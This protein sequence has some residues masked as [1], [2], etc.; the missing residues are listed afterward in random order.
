MK[1]FSDS[2]F[3]PFVKLA[4]SMNFISIQFLISASII[5]ITIIIMLI[6]GG[7]F[8]NKFSVIAKENTEINNRQV[9]HQVNINLD[10]YLRNMIDISDS[11]KDVIY[12]YQDSTYERLNEQLKVTMGMRRDIVSMAVFSADGDLIAGSPMNNVKNNVN[13][14]DRDWFFSTIGNSAV[15]Y[16]SSPHVQNIFVGQHSW[17]VS[18]SRN[19]TYNLDGKKVDGVLLVDMNFSHI[20]QLCE[21]VKLGNKGYIYILDSK[22]DIVY[23]PQQQLINVGLKSEDVNE[24]LKHVFSSYSETLND[25]KR[26]VTVETVNY[27]KWRIVGVFFVDEISATTDEIRFFIFGAIIFGSFFIVLI[28]SFVSSK[29]SQP[30]KELERSMKLVEEGIFDINIDVKGEVEVAK[31]SK[32]FNVMV[33]RIRLLMDQIVKE[34]ESKRKSEL[35]AL[36]AQINPHFLYNTL[37]SIV[38]MAENEKSQDVITMV[39]A[40]A[41]LFRISISRGKNIIS[42]REEIEHARNYLIIQKI[43]YKNRFKYEID[44]KEEALDCKTIKLILQPLIEN[45]IYHGIEYMVD[46]GLIRISAEIHDGKLLLQVSDNG[47]GMKQEV[48]ERLLKEKTGDGEGSGVGVMNVHQRIQLY[49]GKDYGLEILSELEAGTTVKIWLPVSGEVEMGGK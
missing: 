27:C 43:R 10:Y 11:L 31:L 18:L 45:A 15:L 30:I 21:N 22:G 6:F 25:E 3:R 41:K 36:Q 47:L 28:S 5:V 7:I 48:I 23:H 32:T 49:Y 42:V 40:L 24:A 35:N 20:N 46:E 13:I 16:F 29:I 44:I 34:Q 26:M 19:I 2:I 12:V 9:V 33:E 1:K 37:D 38:W 14:A 8:Y 39:T 4:E 17:V